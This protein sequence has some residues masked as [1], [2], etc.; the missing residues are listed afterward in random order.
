MMG[1]EGFLGWVKF[2]CGNFFW[3]RVGPYRVNTLGGHRYFVSCID[4]FT[5]KSWTIC[6]KSRREIYSKI[7]EWQQQVELE[8]GEK[9]KLYRCDNA[10]EYQKLEELIRPGGVKMKS[11][12]PYTP[13]QNGVAER[14]NR[15]VVQIA[16]AM[17]LWAE[18]PQLFWGEAIMTANYITN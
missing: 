5:R 3:P 10:K 17:V 14:F 11:T 15:T 4:D 8:T 12:T 16:R 2:W 7:S 18:L 13:E 1:K 9:V 6:L